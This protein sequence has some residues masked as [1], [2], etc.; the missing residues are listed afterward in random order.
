MA[1]KEAESKKA[2]TAA[3]H[4][5]TRERIDHILDR[6]AIPANRFCM[7]GDSF[8]TLQ[9]AN[10][11]M[12]FL[13]AIDLAHTEGCA[14]ELPD[15]GPHV[16]FTLREMLQDAVRYAAQVNDLQLTLRT[17]ADIGR[18][19]EF[20]EMYKLDEGAAKDEAAHV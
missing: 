4:D 6:V 3:K 12:A 1:N 2:P 14:F 9:S 18:M 19:E 20:I 5:E 10:D 17:H 15:I 7:K 16:M 13:A 8:D 11:L